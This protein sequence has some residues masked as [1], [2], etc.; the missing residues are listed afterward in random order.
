MHRPLHAALLD[1]YAAATKWRHVGVHHVLVQ[2]CEINEVRQRR[3]VVG[4]IVYC[5]PQTFTTII[6][7]L[8][9]TDL[10][11]GATNA[12]CGLHLRGHEH[13]QEEI[14]QEDCADESADAWNGE[15]RY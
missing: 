11:H 7:N 14:W 1:A 9:A 13:R 4:A 2:C 10:Q 12:F 15:N 5:S 3:Y 8:L 6:F